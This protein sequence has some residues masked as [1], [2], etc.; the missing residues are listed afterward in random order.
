MNCAIW[1][2]LEV[3]AVHMRVIYMYF[4]N[5]FGSR[6]VSGPESSILS[7]HSGARIWDPSDSIRSL[8]DLTRDSGILSHTPSIYIHIHYLTLCLCVRTR[9]IV[10]EL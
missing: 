6:I 1:E 10:V 2:K 4:P 5:S 7:R 8:A 9:T 3:L